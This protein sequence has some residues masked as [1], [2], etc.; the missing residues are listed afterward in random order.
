M[1]IYEY[2]CSDCDKVFETIVRNSNDTDVKCPDCKG[3]K[4]QRLLSAF[5]KGSGQVE[6]G[7]SMP[8]SCGPSTGGFS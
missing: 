7:V 8:S 2:H 4:V 6:K 3:E 1:P 5:C